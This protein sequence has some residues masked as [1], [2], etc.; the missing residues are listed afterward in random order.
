MLL[1]SNQ[2]VTN[3]E[4]AME[5]GK[6]KKEM[7]L[8]KWKESVRRKEGRRSSNGTENTHALTDSLSHTTHTDRQ[9]Q[10]VVNLLDEPTEGTAGGVKNDSKRRGARGRIRDCAVCACGGECGHEEEDARGPKSAL[11]LLDQRAISPESRAPQ[12]PANLSLHHPPPN[13]LI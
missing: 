4:R 2:T 12:P 1:E 5:K 10:V 13:S 9:R 6:K 8:S 11:D 3:T 7:L